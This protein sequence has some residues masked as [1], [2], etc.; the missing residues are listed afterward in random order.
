MCMMVGVCTYRFD[1]DVRFF[2]LYI[3]KYSNFKICCEWQAVVVVCACGKRKE[4]KEPCVMNNV[5]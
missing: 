3:Y 1:G 5:I 2:F 4:T